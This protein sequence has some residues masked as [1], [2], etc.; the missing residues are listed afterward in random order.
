MVHGLGGKTIS[1]WDVMKEV[2][3]EKYQNYYKSRDIKEDI[4]KFV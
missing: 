1:S 2:F 4:F 3:L